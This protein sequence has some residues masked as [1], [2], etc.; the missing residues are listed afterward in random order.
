MRAG[1]CHHSPEKDISGAFQA[2]MFRLIRDDDPN[3]LAL[4]LSRGGRI[5]GHSSSLYGLWGC[6]T[7]IWSKNRP[8]PKGRERGEIPFRITYFF[9]GYGPVHV[10]RSARRSTLPT[11]VFGSSSRNS[12]WRGTL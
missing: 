1:H 9:Y 2:A 12:T 6:G 11:L 5:E 4:A 7:L 8:M 3:L 10:V